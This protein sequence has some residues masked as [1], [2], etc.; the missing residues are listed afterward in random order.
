MKICFILPTFNPG[1][2]ENYLLRFLG[3]FS[4]SR[5]EITVVAKQHQDGILRPRFQALGV[6]TIH[7][8]AGYFN[9]ARAVEQILFFRREAFDVICD[10]TGNFA[11]LNMW[12]SRRVGVPRRISLYRRSSH[13]FRQSWH[14]LLY[15]RLQNRLVFRHAT[16]ILS[17]SQHALDTFFPYCDGGRSDDRFRV[18]PNGVDAK[19]FVEA[20]SKKN[21]REMLGLAQDAFIVGHVGRFDPA[22]NHGTMLKVFRSLASRIE[23]ARFVFCGL[24][25]DSSGFRDVVR[26]T[27]M[28]ERV[29]CLGTHDDIP[30]VLTSFDLFYFPS[31]TEGQPNALI[32]A[33][34]SGLPVIT[35]DIPPIREAVPEDMHALLVDPM[36]AE[37]AEKVILALHDDGELR[38]SYR[39]QEWAIDRYDAAENFK[40]FADVLLAK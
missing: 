24:G 33:M 32:E 28:E 34:I 40:L 25:T 15:V 21:S 29:L 17:N 37:A 18:I 23:N 13:A 12:L 1:G 10:F 4:D 9:P 38:N 14:K 8:S 6:R 27:G 22:K 5:H 20:A 35:S 7:R 3:Y 30:S 26:E 2:A 39:C 16:D 11:G 31:V 19:A 36:D